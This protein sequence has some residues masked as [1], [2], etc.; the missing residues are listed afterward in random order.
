M[1]ASRARPSSAHAETLQKLVEEPGELGGTAGWQPAS[2]PPS[3]TPGSRASRGAWP[4]PSSLLHPRKAPRDP[5]ACAQKHSVAVPPPQKKTRAEPR[6]D[7]VQPLGRAEPVGHSRQKRWPPQVWGVTGPP[8][9]DPRSSGKLRRHLQE[10][11]YWYLGLLVRQAQPREGLLEALRV[12]ATAARD[13]RQRGP[14]H[15]ALGT[16]CWRARPD[17]ALGDACPGGRLEESPTPTALVFSSLARPGP[18]SWGASS[19]LSQGGREQRALAQRPPHCQ[20]SPTCW[21]PVSASQPQTPPPAYRRGTEAQR[22]TATC[23]GWHSCCREELRATSG[24]LGSC[25]PVREGK[26][27]LTFRKGPAGSGATESQESAFQDQRTQVTC[28]PGFLFGR[29]GHEC[30]NAHSHTHA[31]PC[32]PHCRQTLVFL[33]FHRQ[34]SGCTERCSKLPKVTQPMSAEVGLQEKPG[35]PPGLAGPHRPLQGESAPTAQ[36][37]SEA[38][39]RGRERRVQAWLSPSSGRP[40]FLGICVSWRRPLGSR[41]DGRVRFPGV[42][43]SQMQ[44][45]CRWGAMPHPRLWG[46]GTSSE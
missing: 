22:G 14:P 28:H 37:G 23:P 26:A 9:G 25:V 20:C 45:L 1:A 31:R 5:L 46:R 19:E 41:D 16:Q 8:A 38:E 15:A 2:H 3:Q 39:M 6:Q 36:S 10:R 33:L 17:A 40:V 29:H 44:R 42:T 21:A 7:P 30:P 27:R 24:H 34:E 43:P 32:D 35:H 18:G 11:S 4:P 12:G 13:P